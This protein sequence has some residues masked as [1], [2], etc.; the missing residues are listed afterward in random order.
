MLA[1]STIVIIIIV[2]VFVIIG[3]CS[4]VCHFVGDG[5]RSF[6]PSPAP[7]LAIPM[8]G[9][10]CSCHEEFQGTCEDCLFV[11]QN[12]TTASAPPRDEGDKGF[13]QFSDD[14]GSP[15]DPFRGFMNS[16]SGSDGRPVPE[17]TITLS[18]VRDTE[19]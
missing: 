15:T 17:E 3:I 12:G 1:N 4:V 11:Q 7:V 6:D 10:H 9:K 18:S 16:K 13:G 14:P 19:L 2:V 8:L 5:G